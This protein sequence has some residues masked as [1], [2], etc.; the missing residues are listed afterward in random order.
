MEHGCP[1]EAGSGFRPVERELFAFPADQ[2]LTYESFL[3]R[4]HPDDR[5]SVGMAVETALRTKAK[6]LMDYRIVWP[7]GGVRW[8]AARGYPHFNE[9]AEPDRLMGVALDI[10]ER[11]QAE[12]ALEEARALVAAVINSTDDFVWSVD[13]ERFGLLTWNRALRDYFF[14]RRQIDIRVGMP[15]E[16]LLPPD[17][18]AV[19]RE[20]Y[21]CRAAGRLPRHGVR[22]RRSHEYSAAVD[23]PDATRWKGLR[24]FGVR[25]GYHGAQTRRERTTAIS[26][27]TGATG[28]SAYGVLGTRNRHGTQAVEALQ[29][30]EARYRH[31]VDT[32]TCIVLE[33][34]PRG[35][36][37]FLN[38]YGLRFFG[39][40]PEEILGH[41]VLGTI[42]QPVDSTGYDLRDMMQR[43]QQSPDDF[44]SSDNE[45]VRKN[46]DKVWIAW[47]NKGIYNEVGQLVR[48]LSVGIDRTEAQ[49]G[50]TGFTRSP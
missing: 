26:G 30:S 23:S 20:F 48:T 31:L 39:F 25:K 9:N 1:V 7:D 15:P 16:E 14:E 29:A 17:Y 36:V 22:S 32:P 38:Q 45:N 44:Y 19:W 34:D 10:T 4:I 40:A 24:H 6:L 47:T 8:I 21:S 35:T 41:N 43:I 27:R 49:A 18:A 2:Q 3:H 11:K 33:W 28:G 13:A 50:G 46:G 37:L 5:E 42:V 12:A